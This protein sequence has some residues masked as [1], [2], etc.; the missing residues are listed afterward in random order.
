R[1]H[2]PPTAVDPYREAY[3]VG[4]VRLAGIDTGAA[5]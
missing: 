3:R 5:K 2:L 1:M 4:N